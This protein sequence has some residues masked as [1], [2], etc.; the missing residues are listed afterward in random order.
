MFA[1]TYDMLDSDATSS[2]ASKLNFSLSF[3]QDTRAQGAFMSFLFRENNGLTNFSNSLFFI[4]NRATAATTNIC[5][6]ANVEISIAQSIDQAMVTVVGP[7]DPGSK[8]S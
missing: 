2:V 8:L 4:M 7:I 6:E 5:L 1:A 3:I